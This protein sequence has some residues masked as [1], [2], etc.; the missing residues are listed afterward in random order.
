MKKQKSNKNKK[1]ILNSKE[2]LNKLSFS[3]LKNTK[4]TDFEGEYFNFIKDCAMELEKDPQ[5]KETFLNSNNFSYEFSE[6]DK[7]KSSKPKRSSKKKLSKGNNNHD[8]FHEFDSNNID[9]DNKKVE[10]KKEFKIEFIEFE[11][12]YN[13]R[14]GEDLGVIG[15]IDELGVWDQGKALKLNWN[16]GNIWKNKISYNSNKNN[17]FEYK[18]IFISNG[19]VKQWEDGNNRKISFEQLRQIIEPHLNENDV[20]KYDKLNGSNIVYDTK[21]FTLTVICEWNKK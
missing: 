6:K 10:A 1:I 4:I 12:K 21:N 3:V 20:L 11:M 2:D 18:F 13:T 16:N 8:N 5:E 9:S 19:R 15:S 17:N 7:T 14:P